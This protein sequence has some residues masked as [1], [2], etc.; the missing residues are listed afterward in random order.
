MGKKVTEIQSNV[1]VQAG[2]EPHRVTCQA[3]LPNLSEMDEAWQSW[4]VQTMERE[5][6][7]EKCL[8]LSP[9]SAEH[10]LPFNWK[11]KNAFHK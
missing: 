8:K 9:T 10:K 1:I 7:E 6:S 3:A 11:G 2:F 4:A 5:K